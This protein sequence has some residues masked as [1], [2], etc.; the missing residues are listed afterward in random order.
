[1]F[2]RTISNP[3]TFEHA[4]TNS[5]SRGMA[6]E[7][8]R[9]RRVYRGAQAERGNCPELPVPARTTRRP[10]SG[11]RFRRRFAGEARRPKDPLRSSNPIRGESYTPAAASPPIGVAQHRLDRVTQAEIKLHLPN[12]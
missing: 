10:R 3:R 2:G 9:R 8:G 1:M 7:S 5:P 4:S 11:S 6:V 12:G